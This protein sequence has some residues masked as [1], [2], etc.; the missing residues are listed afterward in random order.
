MSERKSLKRD[1]VFVG[2]WFPER[3][4]FFLE[5]DKYNLD[6][7]IYGAQWEKD[8]KIF[9][10]LKHRIVNRYVEN[11]KYSKIIGS[12]KI[13]ICL[14][15]KENDDDITTRTVEIPAIGT[16][17]LSERTKIQKKILIENKEA[18]YFNN[19]K[20][21]AQK[22]QNLLNNPRRLKSISK[23]GNLKI[24]KILKPEVTKVI[25]KI[26]EISFTKKNIAEFI[27]RFD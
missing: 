12:A 9:N 7:R 22:C 17:L 24:T 25:K 3:G 13:A 6:F 14:L 26:L 5:F 16:L 4:K 10:K 18:I 15:S 1:I 8:K 23:K 21:C 19:V 2:N 20:E 11:P 27:Y